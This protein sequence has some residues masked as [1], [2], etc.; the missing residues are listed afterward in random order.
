[1]ALEFKTSIVHL[2]GEFKQEGIVY[3]FENLFGPNA[4]CSIPTICDELHIHTSGDKIYLT[5]DRLISGCFVACS[6]T[7]QEHLIPGEQSEFNKDSLII[8]IKKVTQKG[9]YIQTLFLN[10]DW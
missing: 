9:P 4:E 10:P 1:M 2:D 7:K 6:K 3:N 8:F 5:L